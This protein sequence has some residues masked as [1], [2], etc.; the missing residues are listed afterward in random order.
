MNDHVPKP[1]DPDVL[2]RALLKWITPL[3]PAALAGVQPPAAGLEAD[4]PAIVGL[5]VADGL[6]R[7]RGKKAFYAGLLRTFAQGQ[8]GAVAAARA[9]LRSGQRA[10]A[11]RRIHTLKSLAASIGMAAIAQQA[12]QIEAHI[13]QGLEADTLQP[14]LDALEAVLQPFVQELAQKLPA[15]PDATAAKHPQGPRVPGV[16]SRLA[17]LLADDNLEAVEWLAENAV[18]LE[19]A[20]G[21][22]YAPIAD[23]VRRFDCALALSRLRIAAQS[24]GITMSNL[25]GN[26]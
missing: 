21:D 1:I 3:P 6:R 22:G 10:E 2:F 13:R 23:A 5:D 12:A 26:P 8:Q 18:L 25:R 9:E 24:S 17:G 11:Q 7:V 15:P 4:I 16:C 20:L 19:Q 14:A